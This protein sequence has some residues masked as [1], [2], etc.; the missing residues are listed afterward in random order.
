MYLIL[1]HFFKVF[2]IGI[3]TTAILTLFTPM[4]A[5]HSLEMLLAVRIVEGIFEVSCNFSE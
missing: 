2:G 4:A 1:K 3:G 5:K